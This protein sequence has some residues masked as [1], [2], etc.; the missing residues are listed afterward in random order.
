MRCVGKLDWAAAAASLGNTEIL[1]GAARLVKKKFFVCSHR[2]GSVILKRGVTRTFL[3]VSEAHLHRY[4]SEF[5]FRYSHR[6]GMGVDDTA[7]MD[8]IVDGLAGKRLTYRRADKA[9]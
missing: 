6:A 4:L 3:H 9:A 5:D 7:R 8:L 1:V 2:G